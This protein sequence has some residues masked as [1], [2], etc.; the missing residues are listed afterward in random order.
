[1]KTTTAPAAATA[2][3]P[4]GHAVT[5]PRPTASPQATLPGLDITVRTGSAAGDTLLSAFDHALQRAG[6]QDFNLVTL[7]SVIPP[8]SRIRQ[9]DAPLDG[10]HGDLLFCVRAEAYADQPGDTAWA[11]LGWLTDETGGGLFVEHHG[12]SEEAVLEQIERSLADMN[13]RRG[14]G[15]SHLQTAV[16][17]A[18][19]VDRPVCA[20]ALAA[21]R[22]SSWFDAE[23]PAAAAPPAAATVRP[24]AAGTETTV[25]DDVLGTP[26]AASP[27]VG[28]G[29]GGTHDLVVDGW[30]QESH[31]EV[32]SPPRLRRRPPGGTVDHVTV[33]HELD[34]ATALG[35]YP[36]YLQTFSELDTLAAGRQLLHEFE[37]MEEMLDPRVRKYVAWDA[38]GNPLGMS[39]L[40]T[41]LDAVPWINP[42]Y[43]AHRFPEHHARGAI[44]YLGFT[45]VHPDYRHTRVF[46][47]LHE[48][49]GHDVLAHRGVVGWDMCRVNS[50]RGLNLVVER[51]LNTLAD[52]TMETV[53]EQT[54][55]TAVLHGP[56]QSGPGASAS[57]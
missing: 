30:A 5:A 3:S 47:V 13:E 34:Y 51:I 50:S 38:E 43:Y 6:V 27:S 44:Y 45:L 22:V 4:G 32:G 53:D 14:G 26:P 42:A 48:E 19:C 20:L 40:T 55:Y 15:Y 49:I 39:T 37:F 52:A 10:G 8:R 36:L 21:Y 2:P 9:V 16:A 41:D 54:Y 29:P 31:A 11:G 35:Y 33:E 25:E 1:M 57:S 17:S 56:R 12:H 7:S 28:S 23:P 18:Q 24:P 46:R